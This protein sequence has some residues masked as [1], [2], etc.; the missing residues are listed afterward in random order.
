MCGEAPTDCFTQERKKMGEREKWGRWVGDKQ[1]KKLKKKLKRNGKKGV[2]EAWREARAACGSVGGH[3]RWW[4][5]VN[6]GASRVGG[7]IGVQRK[8]KEMRGN[9]EM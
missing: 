1:N 8:R 2:V 3:E 5:A 7:R 9:G 4:V 6:N